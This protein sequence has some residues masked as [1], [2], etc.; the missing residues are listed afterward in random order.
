MK[1]AAVV[2]DAVRRLAGTPGW[3]LTTYGLGEHLDEHGIDLAGRPV[4]VRPPF[5]PDVLDGILAAHDV[6]VLPSVMR[7]TYSIATRE[8]LAAGLPVICTDTLG[9]EEVIEHGGN[10]LVVPAGDAEALAAAIASLLTDPDLLGTLQA[11]ART[12]VAI[13]TIDEQVRGLAD[14]FATLLEHPP[15]PAPA[16]PRKVV[17]VCGIEGAPLR[18][19]AHLPAEALADLGVQTDVRHYRDPELLGLCGTAD[20]VVFYSVPATHQVLELIDAL[21]GADIPCAFDVDDLIF[22]PGIADEIPA[23]RLL[24]PDEARLWLEGVNRYRTTMEA[25]DAYIGST[26]MLVD[27]AA[28][29]SGLPAHRYDNGVGRVLARASDAALAAPR[30]PGPLRIGY[31]SGTTTHDEDWFHIEPAVLQVLDKHPDAEL[32]LGGHLPESDALAHL[33]ERLKRIPFVPW[34]D[35]PAALRDLDVNLAPLAPGSRFN[36]AKSAIK[37]LEAALVATPT[38]ASPTQPFREAIEPGV[39]GLLA[40][41][42]DE[43]VEALELLLS[44]AGARARIGAQARRHALLVW[45][46]ARQGRRYAAILRAI[47][48]SGVT[49]DRSSSWVRV[50]ND[51]PAMAVTLAAYLP[52]DHPAATAPESA[53]S[54]AEAAGAAPVTPVEVNVDRARRAVALG[55]RGAASVRDEGPVVTARKAVRKLVRKGVRMVRVR[56]G[57]KD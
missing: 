41:H 19:R 57:P 37:W 42:P 38:V 43:W 20:V 4:D 5:T 48:A 34:L 47:I 14:Q 55:R 12:P 50:A 33:G 44:D 15:A 26:E 29:V 18:Y 9:P 22:D 10:G 2:V 56:L 1:G 49:R 40:D 32:W 35:L 17:F 6:F 24:P 54:P 3:H 46:P 30:T 51:E 8:A 23:L 53:P 45:S 25:C 11:G 7:E 27:H 13:R 16:P 31:F 36:E 52:T 28:A 21:H 39:S